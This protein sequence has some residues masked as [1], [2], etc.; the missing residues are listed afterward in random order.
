MLLPA[1]KGVDLMNSAAVRKRLAPFPENRLA[2]GLIDSACWDLRAQAKRVPLWRLW[3]GS[4]D[5][6][7]S[8]TVT[9]E[10]PAVMAREAADMVEKHG[11]KTLK[12]KGGQGF[13]TDA[14]ALDEIRAAVGANVAFYV[15]ANMAYT[16]DETPAYVRML[17]EKGATHAEDPCDLRPNRWFDE[18]QRA[19]P[20]PFVVDGRCL[21]IE[22]AELFLERGTR[23]IGLKAARVGASVA[24]DIARLADAAG[25]RVNVGLHAESALGAFASLN[26]AAAFP[27][28]ADSLPAESTFFLS[29]ADQIT[30]ESPKIR[31]GVVTLGDTCG[32]A[33]LVDWDKVERY[34]I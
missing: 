12:I 7:V 23:F 8:W 33:A 21:G 5:V 9:R 29:Y 32:L 2:K 1:L 30:H 22:D 11:F 31:D 34:R 16:A 18:T 17:A 13:E 15:D 20:I 4:R 3:E 19:M 25:C 28:H 26:V 27:R 14:Q 24:L 10:K 6:P